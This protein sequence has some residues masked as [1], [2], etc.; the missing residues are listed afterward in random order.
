[1][2]KRAGKI[3][4]AR[5]IHWL[6]LHHPQEPNTQTLSKEECQIITQNYLVLRSVHGIPVSDTNRRRP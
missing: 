2:E 3:P 6:M 5:R 1:M 4:N